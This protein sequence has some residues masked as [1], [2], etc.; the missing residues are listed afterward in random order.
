LFRKPTIDESVILNVD[1]G[2]LGPY[3]QL[4]NS[5]RKAVLAVAELRKLHGN[6]F[7]EVYLDQFK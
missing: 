4:F 1:L 3:L 5:G 7:V 6:R 2:G